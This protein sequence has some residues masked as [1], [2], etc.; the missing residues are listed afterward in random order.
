[1]VSC[2]DDGRVQIS[3]GL[4]GVQAGDKSTF[5]VEGSVSAFDRFKQL[6]AV[7]GREHELSIW[8]LAT[9]ERQ[10]RARNVPND[11]LDMRRPV[12]VGA[13][14]FIT[15]HTLLIGTK[16]KQ[17]RIYDTRAQRRPVS[18]LDNATDHAVRQL[19]LLSHEN[20]LVAD[21]AGTVLS[22]DL[23]QLRLI[24]RHVGPAGS[25]RGLAR[26]PTVDTLF[27][28]VG[29]DRKLIMTC[30]CASKYMI[31]HCHI[32][33]ATRREKGPL[34]S[35]YCKQRLNAVLWLAKNQEDSPLLPEDDKT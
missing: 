35:V 7:G 31:G 19:V 30:A 18:E 24:A 15:D 17:L 3:S 2:A 25:I 21:I 5:D 28:A 27:A 13:V 16:H 32:W 29:L 12:W 11:K 22:F 14:R 26:H 10:W 6:I 4:N 34:S 20:A 23:R 8:N 1:M 33:D 9:S